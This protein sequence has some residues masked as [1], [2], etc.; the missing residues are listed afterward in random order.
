MSTKIYR[1][2]AKGALLDIYEQA[3][4][5]F[6]NAVQHI[7][8]TALFKIIKTPV[9][10]KNCESIQAILTHVVYAGFGYANS[11]NQLKFPESRR[12]EK[13]FNLTIKE[14]LE[15]LTN[16]FVYTENIFN[17][18][19]EDELQQ[20]NNVLKIKTGWGQLY[21]TE[22]LMEHAIVHLLRHQLQLEKLNKTN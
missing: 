17:E 1:T 10:D 8:D 12:P 22:Q 16:V 14:Y 3:I 2:G 5:D 13:K 7:P 15:D 21:D 20:H 11:I 9:I 4:S 19:E 6:K 18:I